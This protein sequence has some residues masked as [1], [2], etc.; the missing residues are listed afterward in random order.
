MGKKEG[1]DE[2]VWS[3]GNQYK[4]YWK[5]NKLCGKEIYYY[6]DG[7]KYIG[8][9]NNNIKEGIGKYYWA[10]GKCYFGEFNQDRKSGIGKYTWNDG[11]IYLGYWE[12][13]KQNGLGRYTNTNDNKDKFGLWEDGK[14]TKWIDE[15]ELK[16]ETN[17]FH[18]QY[19]Q[20]INF[21]TN[22]KDDDLVEEKI[23]QKI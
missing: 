12:S 5:E 7:K 4:G 8:E 18:N 22:F 23:I 14:R 16:N 1:Y 3:N 2:Y 19:L 6:A 10:D 9:F 15:E 13:N 21:D 17:Q 20:I 11:R